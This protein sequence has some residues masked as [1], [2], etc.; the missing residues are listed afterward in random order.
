MVTGGTR[1]IDGDFN[2]ITKSKRDDFIIKLDSNGNL[3]PSG[4]KK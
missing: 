4:K 1:S 3:K 2:G